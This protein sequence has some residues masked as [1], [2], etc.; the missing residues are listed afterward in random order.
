MAQATPVVVSA[1]PAPPAPL[2]DIPEPVRACLLKPVEQ[3]QKRA[4]N[5]DGAIE[6]GQ[7]VDKT[8]ISCFR[9][10][11]KWYAELQAQRGG[12]TGVAAAAA[13]TKKTEPEK[14]SVE[15]KKKPTATWE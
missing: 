7:K 5:V 10:H 4:S 14:K 13:D 15:V 8:K 3:A 11:M 6:V 9:S 12:G 1:S 2:P